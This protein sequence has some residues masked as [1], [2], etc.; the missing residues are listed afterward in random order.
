MSF[1]FSLSVRHGEKWFN[2]FELFKWGGRIATVASA[3]QTSSASLNEKLGKNGNTGWPRWPRPPPS[4]RSNQHLLSTFH[5]YGEVQTLAASHCTRP[6]NGN[7]GRR[8]GGGGG[9]GGGSSVIGTRQGNAVD[10]QKQKKENQIDCLNLAPDQ[11]QRCQVSAFKGPKCK[12]RPPRADYSGRF[13]F[14]FLW[15]ENLLK[16]LQRLKIHQHLL[17]SSGVAGFPI[18]RFL[19]SFPFVAFKC[20]FLRDIL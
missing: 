4:P 19:F 11:P 12:L 10:K 17:D 6:E 3:V 16:I 14:R 9:G 8:R 7:A 20:Q 5:S 15:F 1:S 18:S 13:P 2:W